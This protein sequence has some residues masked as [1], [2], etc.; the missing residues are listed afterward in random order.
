[1][2]SWKR[3]RENL[4]RL[5]NPRINKFLI[6]IVLVLISLMATTIKNPSNSS[7]GFLSVSD[8]LEEEAGFSVPSW[9]ELSGKLLV[10]M[11]IV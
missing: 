2:R 3:L 6:S 7:S 5:Q 9:A 11:L 4:L 10:Q 8:V 1:M